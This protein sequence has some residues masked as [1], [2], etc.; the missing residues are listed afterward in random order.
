MKYV[1]IFVLCLILTSCAT[2]APYSSTAYLQ[3]VE[4]KVDALQVMSEAT[5]SYLLHAS[6][7]DDLERKIEV[8]YEFS[9]GRR[10]N[11]ISTRQWEI[12]KD[13]N[14]NLLGGFLARWKVKGYFSPF[15]VTEAKRVVAEAF[16]TIIGLESRKIKV[17][18]LK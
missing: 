7:V 10:K 12:M 16:D 11:Q 15:F 13:P 6:M 14:R 1:P 5:G 3:A 4:L 9:K 2:I 18:D 8:A 17:G